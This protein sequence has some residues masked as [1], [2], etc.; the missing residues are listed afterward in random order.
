MVLGELVETC[1]RMKLDHFLTP[2]TKNK[3]KMDER[4]KCETGNHQNLRGESRQN[5]F[6]FSHSN[7]LL[8]TSPVT[9]ETK[10]K[11]NYWDLIKI[12]I[13]Y[14]TKETIKATDGMG[15]DICKRHTG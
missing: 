4:P 3:F 10:A 6:D 15:K 8:N 5:L 9:R 2:Y 7:F 1:R 13:F 11:M 12:K 14:T